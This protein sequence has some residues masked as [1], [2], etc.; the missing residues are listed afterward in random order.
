MAQHSF[1]DSHFW[2]NAY[3]GGDARWDLGAPSPVFVALLKSGP[4]VPGR[5]LVL[6]CGRGHDAVLSARHGFGVTAVDFSSVALR[7]AS[8]LDAGRSPEIQWM[9]ADLFSLP[10]SMDRSFQY[11]IEHVTYCAVDPARRADYANIVARLLAPGGTFVALF[12]PVE[13]RQG[14]PP[15]GVDREE[16]H[17]EFGHHLK[18]ISSITPT[19]S[20]RPRLGREWLTLWVKEEGTTK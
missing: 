20:V 13:S 4:L 5:T 8:A 10:T 15:F 2:D 9:K 16:V 1:H 17:R 3:R 19:E 12:F 11:V 6:G 18:L 7:E 14:G